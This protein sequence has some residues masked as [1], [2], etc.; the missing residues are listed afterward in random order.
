MALALLSACLGEPVRTELAVTGELTLRGRILPVGGLKEKLLAAAREHF[1][2]LALP[3]ENRG[4][5][6]G[7]PPEITAGLTI[8]YIK[9]FRE[10]V[11][12]ALTGRGEE[13][14]GEKDDNSTP[15]GG[16]CLW[17]KAADCEEGEGEEEGD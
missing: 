14:D 12:L 9:D 11:A 3:F 6:E 13:T 5:V 15:F 7:L 8:H 2:E 1:T 4:E 10:L 16:R 17:E